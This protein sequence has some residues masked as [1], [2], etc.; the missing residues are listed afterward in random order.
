MTYMNPVHIPHLSTAQIGPFHTLEK[1]IIENATKIES[2]FRKGWQQH[3][4]ILTCSVDLRNSGF[5]IAAIDTNLFPAGFNN[6][7]PEFYPMAIQAIQ[8]VLFERYPSCQ[9]IL[10]IAES[11]TRNVHYYNSVFTLQELCQRAGYEARVGSLLSESEIIEIAL[12]SQ[13]L[14]LYPIERVGNKIQ[15]D[16][17]TPCLVLLN[18]D[19]SEGIPEI[20]KGIKQPIDPALAL[21]WSFR[22]KSEHFAHYQAICDEFAKLIGID[23]WQINPLFATCQNVD[24]VN[25][26]NMDEVVSKTEEILNK[27]Q[28]KY[29]QYHVKQKP[30]VIIKADAGTYGM[31]VMTV[32]SAKTLYELN[33]KQR[34]NMSTRKGGLDVKN[35]LIQEGIYTFETLGEN[36]AVAEPVVYMFGQ[37]VIGGFYRVHKS[38]KSDQNLNAPGMHFEMLAFDQCCNNP[39]RRPDTHSTENQFYV[40]SV[41]ARL[42]AMASCLEKEKIQKDMSHL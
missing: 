25:K 29:D 17:M 34:L 22:S 19:F 40:Y 36:Q 27:T 24:F 21:G 3:Q 37:Q 16:N 7:N 12:P 41:I 5:K 20:L 38:R 18:N 23:P 14:K 42:A 11:H 33:R 4:P 28:E 30:F 31:A 13:N 32:H 10:I 35:Y 9:N 6:L 15:Y 39:N 1:L 2:W 8:S 26:I